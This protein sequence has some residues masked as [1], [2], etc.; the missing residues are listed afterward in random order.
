MKHFTLFSALCALAL[1]ASAQTQEVTVV[2]YHPAPGQFVNTLPVA[3][4]NSTQEELCK[5]CT[6]RMNEG[7]L[8]HLG[9]YGG[10][11]TMKFDHPVKNLRGSD[12]RI[13][14]NG[15]YAADDPVYGSETIGGSFEPGIVYVGV[16]DD[17]ETCKWYELAG[18]EY[19]TTEIHDFEIT[20]FKPEAE[21]GAHE[22]QASS[23][24]NYIRWEA[25]WT[26][27]NGEKRDST[28]YHIKNIYH[29][30]SYWP[31]FEGKD[32]LT[33]RGGK[34]PN[35]AI[36]Q[37]GRGMYWVLYRYAK[38]SYGYADASLNTDAYST[39]DIDW[40][41]DENGNHVDLQ[42]IN[43]IKVV[44]GIFQYCGWLGETSTEV[45]GFQDLHL[46]PGYDDNPIIIKPRDPSGIS[47]IRTEVLKDG[48]YYDLMGR[49][50]K[51]PQSGLYI[52]N[53]KKVFIKAAIKRE[54]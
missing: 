41:V 17:L 48:K 22:Q 18:S 50:V 37:S 35:N 29:R 43:Y 16:G 26:D 36:E 54:Q 47:A 14:G 30:Q 34:L 1:T 8:V 21:E 5:D 7:S 28:G 9:T 27:K 24:D 15:F 40:A 44:C 51:N 49:V 32:K 11:M 10:Y 46:V 19:Y 3:N 45:A 52:H 20:Y 2:E 33:F 39:F 13:L 42:E 23:Y 6:D 53:G 4:E 12:F 31:H 25:S 38:D